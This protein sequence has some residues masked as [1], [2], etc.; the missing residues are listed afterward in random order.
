MACPICQE[1]AIKARYGFDL[2]KNEVYYTT[3]PEVKKC[4]PIKVKVLS[5]DRKEV[6]FKPIDKETQYSK[7]FVEFMESSWR[8]YTSY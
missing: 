2:V 5:F 3:V 4:C 6:V 8:V 7:S 1:S